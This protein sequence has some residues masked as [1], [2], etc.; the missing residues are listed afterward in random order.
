MNATHG[1][2][3]NN[4]L[5]IFCSYIVNM[6]KVEIVQ[7]EVSLGLEKYI[8]NPPCLVLFWNS[9]FPWYL[10]WTGAYVDFMAFLS[11]DLKCTCIGNV[12][13]PGNRCFMIQGKGLI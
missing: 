13:N 1:S 11:R 12:V 2:D 5:G 8:L 6:W 10:S 4:V 9:L 3:V 7:A